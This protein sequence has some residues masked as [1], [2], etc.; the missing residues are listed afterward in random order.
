[1][2]GEE[3][4]QHESSNGEKLRNAKEEKLAMLVVEK[5]VLHGGLVMTIPR[6][7]K[8]IVNERYLL[9]DK[10]VEGLIIAEL[11]I[12]NDIDKETSLQGEMG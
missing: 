9:G 1:M 7:N 12:G 3:E 2:L 11:G 5:R 8:F 4:E 10:Q 6:K